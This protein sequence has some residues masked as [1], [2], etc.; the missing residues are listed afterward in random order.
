MYPPA[1][2]AL[3]MNEINLNQ[4]AVAKTHFEQLLTA[5]PGD[6]AAEAGLGEIAFAQGNF[7]VAIEHLKQTGAL[8][9]EQPRLLLDL[10][11]ANMELKQSA[12]AAAVLDKIPDSVDATAHFEAGALLATLKNY[13]SAAHHFE[14]AYPK[15][16][17]RYSAGNYRHR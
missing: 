9:Q 7:A 2:R 1:L 14:L 17:D 15:Y 5:V 13:R 10:A 6:V 8:Y 11:R 12:A 4:D 3:A 16:P